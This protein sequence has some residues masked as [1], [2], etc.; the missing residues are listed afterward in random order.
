MTV[1]QLFRLTVWM[2]F[3]LLFFVNPSCVLFAKTFNFKW[4]LA[5]TKMVKKSVDFRDF[6]LKSSS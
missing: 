6:K 2:K 5:N 4:L 1:R 3:E